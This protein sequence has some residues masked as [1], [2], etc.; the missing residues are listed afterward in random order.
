LCCSVAPRRAR[1]RAA[2]QL[3]EELGAALQRS[4][5]KKATTAARRLLLR[6]AAQ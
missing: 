2:V 5:T 3:H 1:S 4:S 6:G